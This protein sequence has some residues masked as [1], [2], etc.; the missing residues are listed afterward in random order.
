[1][2]GALL[3]GLLLW[4]T[5]APSHL[6]PSVDGNCPCMEWENWSVY[7]LILVP[8]WLKDDYVG[9]KSPVLPDCSVHRLYQLLWFQHWWDPKSSASLKQQRQ[10]LEMEAHLIRS[11]C[12][13]KYPL[14][15][16]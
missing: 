14:Q 3:S 9:L 16:R 8:D 2:E 6:G 4:A 13:Q 5:G 15:L 7:T 10:I 11:L 1:M 12:S